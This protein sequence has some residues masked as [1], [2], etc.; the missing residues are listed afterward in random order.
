MTLSLQDPNTH[1]LMLGAIFRQMRRT[2]RLAQWWRV[3]SKFPDNVCF[4]GYNEE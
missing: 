4:D 2:H 3:Y 1:E